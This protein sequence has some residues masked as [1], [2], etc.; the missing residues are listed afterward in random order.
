M[1]QASAATVREISA[2]T[3]RTM[4]NV[5]SLGEAIHVAQAAVSPPLARSV[6]AEQNL[7]DDLEHEFG[8]LTSAEAGRRMGSRSSA[9]R[10]A[11]T[12]ARRDGRLL[13]LRRG[14]YWL[15][16]GFQFDA[17]G[18]R[19]VIADLLALAAEHGRS[20]TGLIQWLCSPTTYLGGA[21]PVDVLDE[22]KRVLEVA[23][24]AFGIQW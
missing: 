7:Y 19:P 16:P 14:S 1:A 9:L 3:E 21:R 23:D 11:A 2:L 20:D 8:L 6:Q 24:Q 5:R 18:V 22:P 4:R 17:A 10:N 12:S 13:A 15:F